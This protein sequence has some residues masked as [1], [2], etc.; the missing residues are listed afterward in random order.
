[1][2][3]IRPLLAVLFLCCGI[4]NSCLAE[5]E[6]NKKTAQATQPA[7][8]NQNL[9]WEELPPFPNPDGQAGIFAGVHNDVLIVAGG[10][11]FPSPSYA[12]TTKKTWSDSIYIL[13]KEKKEGQLFYQWSKSDL[14]LKS[15]R[16]YG[17]SVPT[18]QGLICI[19]GQ[20]GEQAFADVFILSWNKEKSRLEM[21]DLPS[22]PQPLCQFGTVGTS[23]RYQSTTI[24]VAG[25]STSPQIADATNLFLRFT[26]FS[27]K[28]GWVNLNAP[29]SPR[30]L[31]PTAWQH[32][33]SQMAFYLFSGR[34]ATTQTGYDYPLGLKMLTDGWKYIP[35]TDEW[36]ELRPLPAC[37][38][39][40]GAYSW[41]LHHIL[42]LNGADGELL[43]KQVAG[44]FKLEEHPGFKNEGWAYHTVGDS[45]VSIGETPSNQV[46]TPAIR[47]G[48]EKMS[49][50]LIV[51]GE[52]KP[53]IRSSKVWSVTVESQTKPFGWFNFGVVGLYLI[54]I[55]G[56]GIFFYF[57]NRNVDDFFRGGGRIP[58][59]V[60]AFSIFATMLSSITFIA[61]P[62][63]V[64][65]TNWGNWLLYV[66]ILV[67]TPLV[68]YFFL[69]FFRQI[70]S[71]SAYEYLEKRFNLLSRLIAGAVF[72]FYHILRMG[73]VMYLPALALSSI[74][75][76]HSD[77]QINMLYAILMMGVLSIIY[78]SLGG[79]EAVV[80]TD[81]IQSFVLL[82]GA[83]ITILII[84]VKTGG[85]GEFF[86]VASAH[87]KFQLAI[88]DFSSGSFAHPV[89]W[90]ILLGGLGQNLI[91]YGSDQ[92]VI[93][94]YM[95]VKDMKAA[96]KSIWTNAIISFAAG[97][98][99]FL[100]GT[101]LFVFYRQFPERLNPSIGKVDAIFPTFIV[102]ELPIG[103][104]GLV[105]AAILAAAQ[106]TVSTS[107][108]SATAV[109]MSDFIL[110]FS[111]KKNAKRDLMVSRLG[112]LLF[113]I[114][115]TGVAISF[116]YMGNTSLWDTFL[117][118]L[119]L[120]L[121]ALCGL[122]MAGIFL[123]FVNGPGALL[124]TVSGVISVIFLIQSS[125]HPYL[126]G[127]LN[128]LFTFVAIAVWSLPFRLSSGKGEVEQSE[129][130]GFKK[131]FFAQKG[132]G[133]N[134]SVAGIQKK[135]D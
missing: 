78:C 69:P 77:P 47:W 121:G 35:S 40:G 91:P 55:V 1:M 7:Q 135:K 34:S 95:S 27:K 5:K 26:P 50:M 123:P 48:H 101:A 6:E 90:V 60:A 52:I 104:A 44:E 62:G 25:G 126:Y 107:I 84:V 111:K 8:L 19:G 31:S 29:F 10:A 42:L 36:K 41:G 99:F 33:G 108:N 14:K 89:V 74:I 3:Q 130:R 113:G 110:R 56:V 117:S 67:I 88:P 129:L 43:K 21:R 73:I 20:N 125:V 13:Q 122:F 82:G 85:A 4:F 133:K 39:A 87:Q 134:Y 2:K 79:L 57:R 9:K 114:L 30:V 131:L 92:A 94:R 63:K 75:K 132:S 72:M 15:P 61:V 103:I 64:F 98:L 22:L 83:I 128:V 18:D 105:V 118:M 37:M 70:K 109:L 16:A 53:K 124:G 115:G 38:M 12:S 127:T 112:T 86:S 116:V 17:G 28:P 119:G 24:Y 100:V 23:Y 96:K 65:A 93:Q 120:V 66:S 80:W 97:A 51:S 59:W 102:Q 58:F 32:D 45:W 54:G 68:I 76:L 46:T 106:S 81:T 49:P 71:A 11:N